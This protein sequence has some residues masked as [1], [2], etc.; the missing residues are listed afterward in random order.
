MMSEPKRV[1]PISMFI[2]FISDAV[3]MIKNFIIPFFVLI[4]VNSNSSIRFYAFIILGVLLLW[5]AVSTVLAWRRFTYR[6]EDD[7][8]RVE[9]G[10]ITK[11]KKYI[12]LERIQ[13][14]NTSEGIF[15]RIF[16]LVRVQIETAGGT[17]GPE[18]SLTAIT[19]AEA[20]Q[21]KQAIFNRKKSLQQ[22]E[23]VDENGDVPHDP[24]AKQQPVEEEINVSYRM[25]VP[26]LLLAATTSSGIGVIISG[27][28]AIYTQIDEILPLDGFI[29]RFSFLSHASIEI[30]AILIFLAILIAW[31][32]SV[33]VTALQYA[34]F[35]AKRKG[36]DIII[37]RGLIERHQMTIPLARIQAVKIKESI[38]REP[39]GFATVMLVSAG[40]SITEKETSSVLFPLIRKKRISELL[41]QFTDH[42]HLA[43]ET[44][45]KKV[46]KRSL[47]RYLISYGFVPLLVGVILSVRFPPWGYLALIPL[48]IA[49][50]FGYLA[51][52]Q[53]GYTI[54][55]PLIQLTS[56]G[57]GK[58]TG[59]VLRKRMQNYTMTQSFFQKKGRVASIH[60]FVK[61]SALLDSFGVHHLEEEDA[62]RVLDWYSYEKD[63]SS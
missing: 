40:G 18:V 60:T 29:N 34:N 27:C 19:K 47:K 44:E 38:I 2:D 48:P 58:T 4:F 39:F 59:I 8:F 57:I 14:V 22:E 32:L 56:R 54:K 12:S 11:K 45:L 55:D 5:K 49:L 7:E 9:S 51:Y 1:H 61:S 17:D 53:S 46:P 33:G 26:E 50:L 28:I 43:P 15:Q 31:I 16:G 13:T 21:L 6:M 35:T 10:V 24:L 62:A 3:S 63:K 25:G 42:Y 37:T 23:M 20:E 41:S 30:Y 36:N 52:K